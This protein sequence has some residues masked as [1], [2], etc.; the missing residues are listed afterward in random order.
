MLVLHVVTQL[1]DFEMRYC[2]ANWVNSPDSGKEPL[3]P[4]DRAYRLLA[5]FGPNTP[6]AIFDDRL[7][8]DKPT[9]EGWQLVPDDVRRWCMRHPIHFAKRGGRTLAKT[10]SQL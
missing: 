6:R 5:D 10:A 2:L 7:V 4:K 1:L 8:E 3:L 9:A